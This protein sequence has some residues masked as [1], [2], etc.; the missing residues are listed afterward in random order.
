MRVECQSQS[1][2]IS[3]TVLIHYETN[4]SCQWH[5]CECVAVCIIALICYSHTHTQL[6]ISPVMCVC[7]TFVNLS[8]FIRF[9]SSLP[10]LLL[11]RKQEA[12]QQQQQIGG[13]YDQ[14]SLRVQCEWH[15]TD[16]T[17][18]SLLSAG[19]IH[20]SLSLCCS[21]THTHIAVLILLLLPMIQGSLTYQSL[22]FHLLITL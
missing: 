2:G 22:G 4:G 7:G 5:V 17:N 11:L 6:S 21:L 10:L 9:L 1:L 18:T 13:T 3:G 8:P 15:V 16:I 14:K 19:S 20:L 12:L